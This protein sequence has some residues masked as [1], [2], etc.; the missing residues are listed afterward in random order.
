MKRCYGCIL[1][2]V[3]VLL[4]GC[5]ETSISPASQPSTDVEAP[6]SLPVTHRD[7]LAS[8]AVSWRLLAGESKVRILVYRG[9]RLARFG[10]NHVIEVSGLTGNIALTTPDSG[11]RG[12]QY[13]FELQFSA[14]DLMVDRA[15]SRKQQGGDF[16]K[17]LGDSAIVGTRENMLGEAVLD[18]MNFP[19]IH[20]SAVGSTYQIGLNTIPVKID[21]HGVE[22]Q[23]S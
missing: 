16:A 7:W 3:L 10:H 18:A 21:L 14:N 8:E 13:R 6:A 1:L 9:G 22:F 17:P 11:G 4:A 2:G 23:S 12:K 19:Q 20:L 15:E 5:R